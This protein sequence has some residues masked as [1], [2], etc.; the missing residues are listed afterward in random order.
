MR[1]P[2]GSLESD[3]GD[4][5]TMK[6]PGA[7]IAAAIIVGASNAGIAL[8]NWVLQDRYELSTTVNGEDMIG[9]RLNKRTGRVVVCELARNPSASAVPP[10]DDPFADFPAVKGS[11][12]RPVDK[13]V[14][15]C[16]S[17]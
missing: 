5:T 9:W 2:S 1:E 3:S 17:E 4:T 6:T 15:E 11:R 7:I 10:G 16:G 8:A 14:V 13:V 12:N